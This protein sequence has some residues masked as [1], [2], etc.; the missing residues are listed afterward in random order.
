MEQNP[1]RTNPCRV[2]DLI[3]LKQKGLDI[4]CRFPLKS[5][6]SI[7][8]TKTILLRPIS[9]WPGITEQSPA[10]ISVSENATP[11]GVLTICAPMSTRRS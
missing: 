7:S 4:T 8:N 11:G 6:L 5:F 3:G 10:G 1:E 9:S 2:T